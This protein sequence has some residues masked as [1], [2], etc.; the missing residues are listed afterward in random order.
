[1]AEAVHGQINKELYSSYR[2]VSMSAWSQ[3]K[4]LKGFAGWFAAQA[5]EELQ[6][7]LKFYKYLENQGA[8]IRLLAIDAPTA[9][10]ASPVAVNS[11]KLSPSK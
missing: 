9:T 3:A 11:S 1:M 7:A 4:G 2:Y 5:R 8:P 10:F 6:H